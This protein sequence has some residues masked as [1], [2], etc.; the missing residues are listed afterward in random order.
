[1]TPDGRWLDFLLPLLWTIP[2]ADEMKRQLIEGPSLGQ[3][4]LANYL[5]SSLF[6]QYH[7]LPSHEQFQNAG[8]L[9][10]ALLK[11]RM[12]RTTYLH[13]TLEVQY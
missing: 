4:P 5:S 10:A 13:M 9:C 1:M 3:L 11:I 6:F 7:L 12:Q 8:A 2:E